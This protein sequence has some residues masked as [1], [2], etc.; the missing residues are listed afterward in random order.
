MTERFEKNKQA[1]ELRK[2]GQF[3]E[4]SLLY[5]EL[6]ADDFDFFVAAG[7]L[8]CLRKQGRFEEALK[9]CTDALSGHELNNWCRNEVIWTLIQGKLERLAES[10]TID[11]YVSTAESILA[12][13]PIDPTPKWRIIRQV[14]KAAKSCGRWDIVAQWASRMNPETLSPE[15]MKDDNNR[16]GWSDQAVW[17]NYHIRSLVETGNREQAISLAATAIERFPRQHKF[18]ERLHALA[19]LRLSRLSEA[20]SIYANLCKSARPEWWILHEYAQV[21][22]DLNKPREALRTM[23]KA[24]LS[25]KKFEM[26]VSLISD[27]GILCLELKMVEEARNHLLLCKYVRQEQ[28]WSIPAHI[29]AAISVIED[30]VT[31]SNGRPNFKTVLAQCKNFWLRSSEEEMD[32]RAR[33]LRNEKI[34][35][36]LKGKLII[37]KLERPF[38]FVSSENGD[39]YFCVKAELPEATKD[40]DTVVFDAI[41]S[42]DKKKNRQSWKAVNIRTV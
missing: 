40:G 27:I 22:K 41:P 18:F 7:L 2:N 39:S 19:T 35:K 42:F 23:C 12:L 3:Q 15:P 4:A 37:G 11:N 36:A 24:A 38:C 6:L 16:D 17:H 5:S 29:D 9:L 10:A 30:R 13:G 33:T 32:P 1:N 14:L 26:L 20:E 28:G 34:R 31:G 21:L 8:H 25:H